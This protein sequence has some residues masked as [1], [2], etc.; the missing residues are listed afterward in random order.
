MFRN[1]YLVA[2]LERGRTGDSLAVEMGAV[3]G[4]G[5]VKLGRMRG[6]NDDG[7]VAARG[8]GIVEYDVVIA[9]SAQSI[10]TDLERIEKFAIGEPAGGFAFR[11]AITLMDGGEMHLRNAKVAGRADGMGTAGAEHNLPGTA[12]FLPSRRFQ[13][14]AIQTGVCHDLG[15]LGEIKGKEEDTLLLH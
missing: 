9:G 8:I 6:V 15:W 3:F 2:A 5:I 11:R 4:G 12:V 10:Y 1:A 14:H 13:M 7:A